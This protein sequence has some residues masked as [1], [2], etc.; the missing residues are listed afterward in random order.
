MQTFRLSEI[1]DRKKKA[2]KERIRDLEDDL[3]NE[4][5]LCDKYKDERTKLTQDRDRYLEQR[6]DLRKELANVEE[7]CIKIEREF[8]AFQRLS[9][10][11]NNSNGENTNTNAATTTT[12]TLITTTNETT[13]STTTTNVE[14]LEQQFLYMK[15]RMLK[16]DALLRSTML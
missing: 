12:P 16:F 5:D 11:S 3:D 15:D 2:L 8:R 9:A 13:K 6:N 4:M 14:L 10:I 1:L 7:K